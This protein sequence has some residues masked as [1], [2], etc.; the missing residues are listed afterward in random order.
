M[1]RWEREVGQLL[2]SGEITWER[3]RRGETEAEAQDMGVLAGEKVEGKQRV[4]GVE[5]I[6]P[7]L[8]S[9]LSGNENVITF[10][11]GLRGL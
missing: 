2:T 10:Q 3:Q 1:P 6:V 9:C 4:W 5:S 8:G 7:S 11:N